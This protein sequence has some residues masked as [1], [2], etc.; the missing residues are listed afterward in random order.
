MKQ[1]DAPDIQLHFAVFICDSVY[2][3]TLHGDQPPAD[4]HNSCCQVTTAWRRQQQPCRNGGSP[5]VFL[6]A[7]FLFP[8][9]NSSSPGRKRGYW[10]ELTCLPSG[11]CSRSR[12]REHAT[13]PRV[14][15][16]GTRWRAG[17][18]QS[19]HNSAQSP[20]YVVPLHITSTADGNYPPAL[21]NAPLK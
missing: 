20:E 7:T 19:L 3:A 21:P 2:R 9:D 8:S 6:R 15:G 12:G 4:L 16:F 1:V 18:D 11:Y 13:T 14:S 10:Q 5:P 17:I